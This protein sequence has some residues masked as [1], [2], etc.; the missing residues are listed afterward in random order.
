MARAGR[1]HAPALAD[2]R[3][4]RKLDANDPI[5]P[6]IPT[7][8][9]PDSDEPPDASADPA[10]DPGQTLVSAWNLLGCHRAFEREKERL[11]APKSR[12]GA[13]PLSLHHLVAARSVKK[14]LMALLHFHHRGGR[15]L[16]ALRQV[17]R[18]AHTRAKC[19]ARTAVAIAQ[20]PS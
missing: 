7:I 6:Q 17:M 10:R 5:A 16:A 14:A 8:C 9:A 3:R 20:A 15:P 19:E 1:A 4:E 2:R 12:L 18:P 13:S 11:A